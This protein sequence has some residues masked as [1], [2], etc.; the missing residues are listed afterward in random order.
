MHHAGPVTKKTVDQVKAIVK[1]LVDDREKQ[2]GDLYL[3]AVDKILTKGPEYVENEIAR[4]T[5]MVGG[6]NVAPEKRA[7]F[8]LRANILKGFRAGSDEE[9]EEL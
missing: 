5:K 7:Q 6:G 3:K 8:L 1:A 9:N 4:L 2:Y